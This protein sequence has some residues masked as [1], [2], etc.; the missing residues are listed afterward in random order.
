MGMVREGYSWSGDESN[1]CL[2]NAGGAR[3]FDASG[4]AGLDHADDGRGLAVVDWDQDGRL[5]LWYRNRTAPR[6][7]LMVNRRP[8][9][10]AADSVAIRLEGGAANRDAIG[11]VVEL[12]PAGGDGRRLVRSLRAGDLFL[13]QSSKW[14]HFGLAGS[15]PID[16]AEVLWP[17]GERETF[18]GI[19]AGARCL[20]K[21]GT[22]EARPWR[23]TLQR[24]PSALPQRAGDEKLLAA[25]DS[26][27]ARIILPGR[28]PLPPITFRDQAA[29]AGALKPDGQ[30]RLLIL[31]SASCPHCKR[32]LHQLAA[33]EAKIRAAGIDVLALS[34]EAFG[35]PA[36]DISG[37]YDLIDDVGFPFPWGLIDAASARRLHRLQAALFDRTPPSTV[38]LTI[39]LDEAGKAVAIRRGAFAVD[40]LLQD[41]Q[42]IRSADE[43]QLYHL[44]PPLAGTWFTNPLGGAELAAF[45]ARLM[46]E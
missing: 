10:P 17:G 12:L 34:V 19:A 41:W 30:P 3:F 23:P 11:A 8:A 29:Q 15:G 24:E 21:Q 37:A 7:R 45:L 38:P 9:G 22:G 20:L 42:L 27:I 40:E 6:L 4:I 2:V 25:T 16:R 43:K 35:G 14:L 26:G 44:A 39:L 46:A 1:R 5:D 32:Q 36:A 28:V 33:A 18:T 31:W 13:S